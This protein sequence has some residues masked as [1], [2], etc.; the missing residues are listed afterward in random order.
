MRGRIPK[1]GSISRPC[2]PVEMT[3]CFKDID[4]FADTR[5]SQYSSHKYNY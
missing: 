4:P 5:D 3:R 2:Q 1:M